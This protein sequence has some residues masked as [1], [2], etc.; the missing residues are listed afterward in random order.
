LLKITGFSAHALL[1]MVT[2]GVSEEAI[3]DAVA[4]PLKIRPMSNGTIQ[5]IGQHA[6]VVLNGAGHVVTVWRR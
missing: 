1:R 3:R 5:Y 2:R 4:N 6:G